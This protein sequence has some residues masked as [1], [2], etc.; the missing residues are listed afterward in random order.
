MSAATNF[1]HSSS[2]AE[3]KESIIR[4][5]W[6][7]IEK[8]HLLPKGG[9]LVVGVSGGPDSVCLLHVLATLSEQLKAQLHVAHLNHSLRGTE[10]DADAEYV[11]QL[12]SSLGVPATVDKQDVAAYRSE[13][14]LSLEEAARELRYG[15]FAKIAR[16]MGT[17]RVAVGHTADDSV[18]TILMNLIRGTGAQGLQGLRPLSLRNSSSGSPLTVVRPLL[19]MG[20]S[21]VETYCQKHQLAPR[22]DSSNLSSRFLRNR[23]RHELVPWLQSCN[24]N[25]SQGLLNTADIIAEEQNFL[26]EQL[27]GIWDNVVTEH[28]G[29]LVLHTKAISALQPAIQRCL[30]REVFVRTFGDAKDIESKHIE[31]AREALL[32]PSGKSVSLPKGLTFYVEYNRILVGLNTSFEADLPSLEPE[33]RLRVPGHTL[34]PGWHVE[35]NIEERH[36]LPWTEA[37]CHGP[38]V[39][40]DTAYLDLEV[41]G[42]DIVV[43]G[44]RPGDRFQPLGMGCTKRLQDFMVDAHIPRVLRDRVPLIC[45]RHQI[46]W[47][48]GW[49][50]DERAKVREST[51]QV[52]CL[53]FQKA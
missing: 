52:L 28:E 53:R 17:D 34:L 9:A 27:T 25:I 41:A 46:L 13:H 22:T 48:M 16:S 12:A 15:F 23:I 1:P 19:A 2:G 11:S 8:H 45:S 5:T 30:L 50:I 7:L 29:Q 47:V 33:R 26:R 4:R 24:P 49:R 40:S 21:E 32:L 35:A 20:R 51:R 37:P 44:R 18:E 10:S 31:K 14:H 36:K 3:H 42:G 6:T 43:R 38:S 39:C